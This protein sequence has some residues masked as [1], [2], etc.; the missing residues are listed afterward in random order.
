M[1]RLEL[2]M[3][4]RGLTRVRS[5]RMR[6][7]GAIY[8][9]LKPLG[10]DGRIEDHHAAFVASRDAEAEAGSVETAARADID[11]ARKAAEARIAEV[12]AMAA[13]ARQGAEAMMKAA[14]IPQRRKPA[15]QT[16]EDPMAALDKAIASLK[17]QIPPKGNGSRTVCWKSIALSATSSKRR[18]ANRA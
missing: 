6:E 8:A 9:A 18:R 15:A 4:W 3:V 10:A 1:S 17:Q 11:K 14:A 16:P 13:S 2:I 7:I 5:P 12:Q